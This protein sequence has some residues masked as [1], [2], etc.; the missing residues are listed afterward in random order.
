MIQRG[1]WRLPPLPV[2]SQNCFID[3]CQVVLIEMA[4]IGAGAAETGL[5]QL[6]IKAELQFALLDPVWLA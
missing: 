2:L 5:P 4:E 3:L 6:S 1:R